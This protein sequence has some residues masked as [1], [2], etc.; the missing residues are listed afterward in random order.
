MNQHDPIQLKLLFPN[1]MNEKL[2]IPL[3][4]VDVVEAHHK[5][6]ELCWIQQ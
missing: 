3:N 2:L 4:Q 1:E 5:N 6:N